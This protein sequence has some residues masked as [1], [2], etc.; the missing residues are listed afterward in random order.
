MLRFIPAYMRLIALH[1]VLNFVP[2]THADFHTLGGRLWGF[3]RRRGQALMPDIY[4]DDPL[5]DLNGDSTPKSPSPQKQPKS[6]EKK[7]SPKKEQTLPTPTDVPVPE[8]WDIP[9]P[10][11]KDPRPKSV[12]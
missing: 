4:I 3:G 10:D 11:P 12:P 8:P 9:P 6:P 7:Q 5:A 2:T 1:P